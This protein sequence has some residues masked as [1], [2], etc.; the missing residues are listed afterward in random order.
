MLTYRRIGQ[1]RVTVLRTEVLYSEEAGAGNVTR[2]VL[3]VHADQFGV[4]VKINGI[5]GRAQPDGDEENPTT[6]GGLYA[7]ASFLH[8]TG[9]LTRGCYVVTL[10]LDLSGYNRIDSCLF[11]NSAEQTESV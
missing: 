6:R 9:I 4:S 3:E 1:Y 7:D 5:T 2:P 8:W 11:A 10:A